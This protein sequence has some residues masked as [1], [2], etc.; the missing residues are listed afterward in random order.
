[1]S[2]KTGK[3]SFRRVYCMGQKSFIVDGIFL[4]YV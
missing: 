3:K 2:N 1:M 4:P